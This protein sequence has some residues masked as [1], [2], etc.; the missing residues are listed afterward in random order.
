[1]PVFVGFMLTLSSITGLCPMMSILKL[2]PWNRLPHPAC[3]VSE[4]DH[5]S[6]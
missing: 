2:M 1:V 5:V 6:Q 4:T 3:G